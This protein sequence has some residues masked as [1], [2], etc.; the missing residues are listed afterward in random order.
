MTTPN[1]AKVQKK[2]RTKLLYHFESGM[3][4]WGPY[5]SR[6]IIGMNKQ[7]I[8]IARTLWYKKVMC[9]KKWKLD[10]RL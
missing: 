9:T 5:L 10:I 1:H 2:N 7:L 4:T 3:V 8:E 6:L